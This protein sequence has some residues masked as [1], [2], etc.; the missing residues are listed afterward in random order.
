MVDKSTWYERVERETLKEMGME[1]ATRYNEGKPEW[2]LVDFPS[3]LPLVRVLMFGKEKYNRNNWKKGFNKQELL[4]SLLRHT[5]ALASGEENDPE[6]G[7]PHTAGIFFNTMAY[8]Y[9]TD[10]NKFIE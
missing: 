1:K 8:Q 3:L 5:L 9:C 4:D 6:H 7:L 10:N 2:S